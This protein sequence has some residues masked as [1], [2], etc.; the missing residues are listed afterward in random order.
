M[1]S[2]KDHSATDAETKYLL[3]KLLFIIGITHDIGTAL[4]RINENMRTY[5]DANFSGVFP[6]F[7]H[8]G[9]AGFYIWHDYSV[10]QGD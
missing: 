10:H 9:M 6:G 1:I 4:L 5:R 2:F 3:Y 8:T 7:L